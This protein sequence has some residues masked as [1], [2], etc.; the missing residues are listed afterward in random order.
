MD[1]EKII[2]EYYGSTNIIRENG[3][4]LVPPVSPETDEA[5][6]KDS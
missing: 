6:G 2:C 4:A 5:I 3:C 1:Q